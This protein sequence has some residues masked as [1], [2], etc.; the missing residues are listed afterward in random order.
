MKPI[1]KRKPIYYEF[2]ADLKAN[3]K[4][5]ESKYHLSSEEMLHKKEAGTLHLGGK[6]LQN[7]IHKWAVYYRAYLKLRENDPEI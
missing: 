2:I 4:K 6:Y 7:E 5:L 3:L 1:K